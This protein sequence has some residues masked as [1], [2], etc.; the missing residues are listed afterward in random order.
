MSKYRCGVGKNPG[1]GTR[2]PRSYFLALPPP[3]FKHRQ[4]LTVVYLHQR[5][6]IPVL[7]T[8]QIVV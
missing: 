2:R 1:S 7:P 3:S 4:I 5:V 6:R 8:S